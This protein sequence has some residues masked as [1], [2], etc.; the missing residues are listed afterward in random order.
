MIMS[1]HDGTELLK[2]AQ[3]K[4]IEAIKQ[5]RG[6]TKGIIP[7]VRPKNQ[8]PFL[9]QL[10]TRMKELQAEKKSEQ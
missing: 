2:P 1:E 8:E 9:D 7:D 6:P 3:L 4:V 10:K 5:R